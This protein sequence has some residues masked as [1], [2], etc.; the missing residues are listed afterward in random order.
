MSASGARHGVA[1][2]PTALA[3]ALL[4][5]YQAVISPVLPVRCKY[6]PTCSAY[7]VEA[8]RSFGILKGSALA[9]WR[10]LRCNPWSV[11]GID[12]VDAQRLFRPRPDRTT[13]SPS[14]T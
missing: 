8:I 6:H 10:L 2:V 4:R 5:L 9:G 12:W 1:R 14:E 13:P 7:A 3:L 11:G